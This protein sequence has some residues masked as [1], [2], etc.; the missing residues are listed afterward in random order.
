MPR[1]I[2]ANSL[3]RLGDFTTDRRVLMLVAMAVFVG[4]GGAATAWLLLHAIAIVTNAVWLQTLSTQTLSMSGVK[5]GVWMVAA[6][7]STGSSSA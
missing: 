7:P 3:P 5:P 1:S 4:A 6:R 2:P